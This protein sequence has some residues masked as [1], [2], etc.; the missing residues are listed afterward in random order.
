M[1]VLQIYH[2]GHLFL[3]DAYQLAQ[4]RLFPEEVIEGY[5]RISTLRDVV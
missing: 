5:K 3:L 2:T 1:G 4:G